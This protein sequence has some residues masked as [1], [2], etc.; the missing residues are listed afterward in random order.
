[1]AL[2]RREFLEAALILGGALAPA[3]AAA[4]AAAPACGSTTRSQTEGPFYK[5]GA[6]RRTSLVEPGMT[7]ERIVVAGR[8]LTAECVPIPGAILDV[9]HADDRG[10]YDNTGYR[11][12][13]RLATDDAGR[14]RFE[15]IVPA[16]YVGRTR[17]FHVKVEAP[18]RPPLTTQLYFPAEPGNARDGIFDPALVMRVQESP[19]GKVAVFDF[20]LAR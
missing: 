6:P 17:H 8:V 11:L 12:R 14:F 3:A 4:Q 19:Q 20:V 10:H 2:N 16:A 15:T 1:M 9:W 13:G 7:G 5:A 18:G